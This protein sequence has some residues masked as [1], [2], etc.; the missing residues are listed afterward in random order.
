MV[1]GRQPVS[2]CTY[3]WQFRG[4]YHFHGH[5]LQQQQLHRQQLLLHL[6]QRTTTRTLSPFIFL[7]SQRSVVQRIMR[8]GSSNDEDEDDDESEIAVSLLVERFVDL[9][10]LYSTNGAF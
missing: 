6:Q 9:S 4:G 8:L 10:K 7:H 2:S 1:S 5:H 3:A